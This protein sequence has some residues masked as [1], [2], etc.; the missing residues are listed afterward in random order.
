MALAKFAK[1][2]A[3][4]AV[5]IDTELD[6]ET[7]TKAYDRWAPVYDLVFGAVFEQGR[8]A[9]IAAA[10]GNALY[11]VRWGRL[12]HERFNNGD[13]ADLFNEAL[14]RDPKN[15]D[16]YV[17]LALVGAVP[18]HDP[19]WRFQRLQF[20]AAALCHFLSIVSHSRRAAQRMQRSMLSYSATRG[21]TPG[22]RTL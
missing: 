3:M 17:G 14:K 18:A 2:Q 4:E 22:T 21:P 5:A 15:A 7:V 20:C 11:R 19:F 8:H 10:D 9:A 13:A 16:A 6:H 12:L 1:T